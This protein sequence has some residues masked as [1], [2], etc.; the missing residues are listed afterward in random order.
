MVKFEKQSLGIKVHIFVHVNQKCFGHVS[1]QQSQKS[2]HNFAQGGLINQCFSHISSSIS[3]EIF[4]LVTM[5][6]LAMN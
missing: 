3:H 6:L 5:H 2:I 4:T 1:V